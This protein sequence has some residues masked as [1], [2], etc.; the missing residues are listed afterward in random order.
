MKESIVISVGGSLIVPGTGLNVDF[1]RKLNTFIRKNI[2]HNRR[3]F[4]VAGG[5]ATARQY[6]DAGRDVVH[7]M[8]NEDLDWL[9]IHSTHLNA[10][11]LRTIFRDIAHPRIVQNYDNK[12]KNLHESVVIG[13]GWKPGWSTDYDAVLFARDY[14]ANLIINLSNI[15]YV[16]TKDPKIFEDATIIEKTTWDYYE[17]LIGDKWTP[18]LNTPFDPVAAQLAKNHAL[19]VIITKGDD[20]KNLQHI[21]D[22]ESFKG[23]VIR[24]YDISGAYYDKEYYL[25]EKGEYRYV[26][27]I[28]FY[29]RWLQSFANWYR[30]LYI[31][32]QFN[33]K[34]VLDVGCG[35]GELVRFLRMWGIDARGVDISKEAKALAREEARPFISVGPADA[36]PFKDNEFDMVVS[37][38]VME[39]ID[40]SVMKKTIA[41]TI[42]V[43]KKQILH[44]IYTTENFF[45]T[46][47][48]ADDPA[49]AS[50]FPN[51]FWDHLFT[52]L[53]KASLS[54]K[55]FRLPRFMESIYLLKKN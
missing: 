11:L 26:K 8:T 49:R 45:I 39:H 20:F 33:P 37:F 38:D 10:H 24:P 32:L 43:A 22:G 2:T 13:G 9:G 4:L 52:S 21:I 17:T 48:H 46:F 14:G 54:H 50:V 28:A 3:F 1:L 7:K 31:K 29:I 16:Y 19:T 6:I 5:G 42:R 23:S 55:F 47:F 36:L 35:T 15:Y 25:G 27:G 40:R 41:E 53:S 44:K 34:T 51:G 30:A 12:V 18:G